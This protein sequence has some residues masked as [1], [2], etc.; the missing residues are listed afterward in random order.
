M[1]RFIS[2]SR[3]VCNIKITL[4]VLFVLSYLLTWSQQ[5]VD[6][7]PYSFGST[8]YKELA[9]KTYD[10]DTS[11]AALILQEFGHST[12][13]SANNNNLVYTYYV[14]MKILKKSGLD[15]ANITI[16]LQKS[17]GK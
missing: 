9:I 15:K 10:P 6:D 13:E 2:L 4:T 16:M 11:A 7:Q 3:A 14:K 17:D 5:F 8:T 1:L 12:V